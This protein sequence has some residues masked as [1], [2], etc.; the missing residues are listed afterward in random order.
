MTSSEVKHDPFSTDLNMSENQ[1]DKLI[2]E[3]NQ[4]KDD[5][6]DAR[7]MEAR[8]AIRVS[9]LENAIRHELGVTHGDDTIRRLRNALDQRGT[10]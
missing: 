4:L 6:Q 9:R 7:Q 8:L 2:I 1:V 10:S 3:N 5:L